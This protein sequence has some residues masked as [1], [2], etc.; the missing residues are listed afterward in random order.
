M[1]IK[2]I[3]YCACPTGS[4]VAL[5]QA[6][7][8]LRLSKQGVRRQDAADKHPPASLGSL[9][10]SLFTRTTP[11]PMTYTQQAL[12]PAPGHVHRGRSPLLLFTA[13]Y[14]AGARAHGPPERACWVLRTDVG[15]PLSRWS[16]LCSPE[17]NGSRQALLRT[18]VVVLLGDDAVVLLPFFSRCARTQRGHTVCLLSRLLQKSYESFVHDFDSHVS[19]PFCLH[20]C[21]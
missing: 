8:L 19:S 16:E 3:G 9:L 6:L 18:L 10:P 21:S 5:S 13:I 4:D 15:G 20:T 17:V 1:R 2:Q 11:R 7:D 12:R 14:L